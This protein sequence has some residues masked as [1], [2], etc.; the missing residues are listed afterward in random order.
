MIT[1]S[2][3]SRKN[4]NHCYDNSF[5]NSPG[6]YQSNVL[7]IQKRSSNKR[8]V[9]SPYDQQNFWKMLKNSFKNDVAQERDQPAKSI[10]EQ[11]KGDPSNRKNVET[12]E[13]TCMVTN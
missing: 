2:S 6:E 7:D 9:T 11:K 13:N 4:D 5:L 10:K 12:Y 8:V 1:F 3:T